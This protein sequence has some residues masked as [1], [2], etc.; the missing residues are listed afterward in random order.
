MQESPPPI[1]AFWQR[2]KGKLHSGRKNSF[3][4]AWLEAI[5]PEKLEAANWKQAFLWDWL[6]M[7]I[8]LS[9]GDSKL[10]MGTKIREAIS[11]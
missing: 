3:R 10:E 9:Q 11:F 7:H 1:L 6:A 5:G 8:W 2:L 4:C